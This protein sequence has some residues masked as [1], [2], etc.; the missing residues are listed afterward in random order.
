[1]S[2]FCQTSWK[3]KKKKEEEAR[4]LW[5]LED[6]QRCIIKCKLDNQGCWQKKA[7]GEKFERSMGRSLSKVQE[8]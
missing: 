3:F 8:I 7:D 1:M 4:G 6:G 2:F 5:V